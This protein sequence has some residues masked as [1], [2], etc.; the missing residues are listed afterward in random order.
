MDLHIDGEQLQRDLEALAQFGRSPSGGWT[1]TALSVADADARG[2]VAHRLRTLGLDIRHDEVGNLRAR[3]PGRTPDA[4]VVMTGSHLDTV[5]SGGYL[6]GPLGVVG[7]L[8]AVE[9][10]ARAKLTTQRPIEI[11]VFVGEEGSRFPRGTIG[12]A[13]VAGDLL[14]DE[15][16]AL[17]DADG[18]GFSEA[19]ATYRDTGPPL[20]ARMAPGTLHAFIELHIEQ[21]GVL[22]AAGVPIGAVTAIAGLVQHAVSFLGDANHAGATPMALRRDALCAAAEW[23]LGLERAAHEIG[24]GAVATVGKLVVSPGGKNIIPGRVDAIC[25]LRASDG[26]LLDALDAQV[27]AL[28]S[29]TRPGIQVELRPLQ[30]VEPGPMDE[31]IVAAIEHAAEQTGRRSHRMVSGAIHDALHMAHLGPSSMIFV[32]SLAGKS[33]CPEEASRSDDL[34][35]GTLVLAHTLADLAGA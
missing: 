26:A 2:Y 4:P 33:H 6:D 23:L 35:T 15:I 14:V 16:L 25:D 20:P 3:R 9:A 22:E 10:I 5:P 24:P 31:R 7:A 17:R 8:C 28:L 12:S 13:A 27:R 21:G 32:P 29:S 11:V 18:I 19:L 1:R 34:I 30:R